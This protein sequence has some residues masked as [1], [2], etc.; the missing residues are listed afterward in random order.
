MSFF[1]RPFF[2]SCHS[3]WLPLRNPRGRGLPSPWSPRVF[4][5]PKCGSGPAWM[6]PRRSPSPPIH[7]T[8]HH[9]RRGPLAPLHPEKRQSLKESRSGPQVQGWVVA[10]LDLEPSPGATPRLPAG[11]AP[12]LLV[13]KLPSLSLVTSHISHFLNGV[14]P[15]LPPSPS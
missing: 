10:K 6:L 11:L 1:L 12:A 2:L 14:V 13:P 9:Q 4:A 5:L 15:P 3:T 7:H 8:P